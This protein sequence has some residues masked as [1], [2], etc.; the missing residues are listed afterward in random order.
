MNKTQMKILE[1]LS[2][3]RFKIELARYCV[4]DVIDKEILQ[5]LAVVMTTA[6]RVIGR[7]SFEREI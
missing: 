1:E 2:N 4:D 7:A 6:M 5:E 3:V